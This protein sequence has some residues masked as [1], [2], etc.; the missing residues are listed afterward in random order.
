MSVKRVRDSEKTVDIG[1][2]G[3]EES[4]SRDALFIDDLPIRRRR[5]RRRVNVDKELASSLDT[6][7]DRDDENAEDSLMMT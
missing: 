1:R 3:G 6:E 2:A 5:Q 7:D 4:P